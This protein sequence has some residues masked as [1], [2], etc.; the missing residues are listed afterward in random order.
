MALRVGEGTCLKGARMSALQRCAD[1]IVSPFWKK[2]TDV[3]LHASL[4]QHI[5]LVPVMVHI[6]DYRIQIFPTFQLGPAKK[7]CTMA[8]WM[9]HKIT[10]GEER[11]EHVAKRFDML[12]MLRG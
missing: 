9:L 1:Q 4:E 7:T 5:P 10:E 3:M 8:F 2:V 6:P 12:G 11:F